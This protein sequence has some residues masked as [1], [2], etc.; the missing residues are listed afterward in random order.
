VTDESAP[1][2]EP[3]PE[4]LRKDNARIARRVSQLEATLQSV[5]RIRDTNARLLDRLMGELETERARSHELL[6]N[7]LPQPIIDRL[8]AGEQAIADRYDDVAVVFS[9]FVGFTEISARLPVA[10]L[11]SS[12]NALFSAFDA[13]CLTLGV[14]KI[15]TIGDA[16]MAAAGLPGTSGDHVAAAADLALAMQA[17]VG[18]VGAPWQVRIGLHSGPVAGSRSQPSSRQ[19]W[20]MPSSS[21]PAAP[22]SSRARV[23][24]RRT[25]SSGV[26]HD[27]PLIAAAGPFVLLSHKLVDTL[28]PYIQRRFHERDPWRYEPGRVEGGSTWAMSSSP[29]WPGR[30]PSAVSA[31]P[32][33]C[34]SRSTGPTGSCSASRW[35][36]TSGSRSACGTRSTGPGRTSLA[37]ARSTG[38]GSTPVSLR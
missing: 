35:P 11:V 8:N 5:E 1:E 16:Y 21:S 25:T 17:A 9:D 24:P 36:N 4:R 33:R 20:A 32:I 19:R 23:R 29:R 30:S 15:K 34:H 38:R 18:E 28:V 22:S 26:E 3:S 6:L 12:L 14:E 7:V 31:R 37:S 13:A 27:R 10:T 2:V